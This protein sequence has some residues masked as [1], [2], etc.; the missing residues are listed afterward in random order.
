VDEL[1]QLLV[2]GTVTGSVFALAA[3]GISLVYG[4]LRI[5]NFAHGDYLTFGAYMALL[6]NLHWGQGMLWATLFAIALTALLA[7]VL[8]YVLW[9]PMRRKG[10]KFIS[11]FV[12][13]IGLA[14]V[15]RSLLLL[16]GGAGPR[17]YQ[18]NVFQVYSWGPVRLSQSQLLAVA[19]SLCAIVFLA[20]LLARTQLGKSMRAL[21]DNPDLAA[22]AGIDIDRIVVYT[23]LI[24]GALAGLAG[25][26][27]GLI[28]T[29][30]DPNMGFQLLLPVF[31]AVVLG[32]IGS[33]YGALVGGLVLGI[34]EELST[35]TRLHGGVNPTWKPVVAFAVLIGVLLAR[36]TGLLGRARLL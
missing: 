27:A 9:R 4:T 20:L 31:A 32:G 36:P 30:F 13:S 18:I 25:V 24:A 6:V 1:V 23:W 5:V 3:V 16:G 15:L 7:I 11:L 8:E 35:W 22:V 19:I 28:Q 10:A 2:N 29:S 34:V 26:L 33:A 14:L 12:T 17:T 21:S